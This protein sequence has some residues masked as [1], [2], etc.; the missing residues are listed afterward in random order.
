MRD[1]HKRAV[2]LSAVLEVLAAV[3]DEADPAQRAQGFD[4][5]RHAVAAMQQDR[6]D[7]ERRRAA[8]R[9]ID[10][11]AIVVG[12]VAAGHWLREAMGAGHVVTMSAAAV[13]ASV[14]AGALALSVW[15]GPP[16]PG[17]PPRAAQPM[18]APVVPVDDRPPGEA[19]GAGRSDPV[20]VSP[21]AL[22]DRAGPSVSLTPRPSPVAAGPSPRPAPGLSLP[23]GPPRA[24]GGASSPA[25]SPAPPSPSPSPGSGSVSGSP[26]PGAS[27]PEVGEALGCLL[28]QPLSSG[29][30]GE[31]C[32]LSPSP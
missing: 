28:D 6:E 11:G 32:L 23:A 15:V 2:Q 31:G 13:S 8:I 27:L 26:V 18:A 25:T 22:P 1:H 29:L 4:L 20:A 12:G 9:V 14:T 21:S 7:H 16:R 24:S 5:V 10:G 30:L 19:A 3:Q 17:V